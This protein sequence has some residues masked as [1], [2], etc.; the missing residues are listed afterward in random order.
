VW[1]SIED[2]GELVKQARADAVR[3]A[4]EQAQQLADAAGVGLGVIETIEETSSPVYPMGEAADSGRA[5]S[6]APIEPGTQELSVSVTVVYR[7]A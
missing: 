6:P 2:T 1:F 3:M 7:I 5:S 4:G